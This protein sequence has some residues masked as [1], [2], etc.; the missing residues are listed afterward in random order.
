MC[1]RKKVCGD[2]LLA[3][4]EAVAL[5]KLQGSLAEQGQTVMTALGSG[6]IS[7]DEAATIMQALSSQ[8]RIVEVEE[9]ERRVRDLENRWA[10]QL[11]Q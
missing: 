11:D 1:V 5:G 10:E 2:M 9:L 7:P 8:A 3:R 6:C 4:G